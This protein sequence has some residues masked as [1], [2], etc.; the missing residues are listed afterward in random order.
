M[1]LREEVVSHAAIV[2]PVRELMMAWSCNNV[3]T[4]FSE[5]TLQG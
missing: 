1:K 5:L 4:A 3:A 2:E